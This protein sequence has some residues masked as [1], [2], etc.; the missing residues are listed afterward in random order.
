MLIGRLTKD[1]EIIHTRSAKVFGS[2]SLACNTGKDKTSF[3]NLTFTEKQAEMVTKYCGKGKRLFVSG[4]I[5]QN[6][7][8]YDIYVENFEIIDFK[9]K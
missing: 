4:N 2:A 5:V 3:F 6:D 9:E 1:V 7:K 8:Y